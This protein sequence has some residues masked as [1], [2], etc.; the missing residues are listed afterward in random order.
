VAKRW[1]QMNQA[2]FAALTIL[3]LKHRRAELERWQSLLCE[4]AKRAFRL[5]LLFVF[6][7]VLVWHIFHE[8]II[9]FVR[10][11]GFNRP[12]FACTQ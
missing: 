7:D 3:L 10:P 5:R 12:L 2:R 6:P 9:N 11:R 1:D 4:I 8:L